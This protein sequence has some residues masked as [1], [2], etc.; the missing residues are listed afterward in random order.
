MSCWWVLLICLAKLGTA[1]TGQL[2]VEMEKYQDD[3][4][5]LSVV[6]FRFEGGAHAD[7]LALQA[8]I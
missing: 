4:D 2:V 1:S 7:E 3:L 6:G 5:K 8:S